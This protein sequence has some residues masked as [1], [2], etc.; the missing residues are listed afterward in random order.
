MFVCKHSEV[1]FHYCPALLTKISVGA[2]CQIPQPRNTARQM[3][4]RQPGSRSLPQ[5]FS[6]RVQQ[7]G[8]NIA[9]ICCQARMRTAV[10]RISRLAWGTSNVPSTS[11]C[12]CLLVF[13]PSLS[14]EME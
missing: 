1:S 12:L 3:N 14:L 4:Q 8:A 2:F 7:A 13:P 6:L 5:K 9:D 10:P 11:L